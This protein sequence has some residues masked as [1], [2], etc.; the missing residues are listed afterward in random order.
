MKRKY[1]T[2]EI[3]AATINISSNIL[4]AYSMV[5]T[6]DPTKSFDGKQGYFEDEE[7]LTDW[8]STT[9]VRRW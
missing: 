9:N 1:L 5:E 6:G 2:P 3:C 4:V 8:G 7:I